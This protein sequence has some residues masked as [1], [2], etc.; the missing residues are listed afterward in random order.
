VKGN[1]F[2]WLVLFGWPLVVLAFFA[3]R[4]G[5][6]RLARTT[7]WMMLLPTMFLPSAVEYDPPGLPPLDK[8]RMAFLFIALAL[9][10]FHRRD[11]LKRAPGHNFP[12]LM[13]LIL[14]ASIVGTVRTNGDALSFGRL[15]LPGLTNH[16]VLSMGTMALLDFYLP[17]VVGQRVFRTEEDLRDL[18]GVLSLCALI[19]VPFILFEVRFSPQLHNWVYGF[20]PHSWI[21]MRRQGGFRP[22]IFMAHGLSVAMFVFSGVCASLALQRRGAP[23]ALVPYRVRTVFGWVMSVLCK[24]MAPTVY[25]VLASLLSRFAGRRVMGAVVML[26]VVSALVYPVVR[27]NGTAPTA[28]V[29][30]YLQGFSP[31]RAQSLDFRFDNEDRL[32]AHANLRP[33]FGWGGFGR[34]RVYSDT[35]RDL[36]VTDGYWIILLGV[37]GYVGWAAV[38]VLH[39]APLVRFVRRQRHM[40]DGVREMLAVFTF[41]VA[42][43][44]FDFLPNAPWDYLPMAYAGAL[45]TVSESASRPPPSSHEDGG[46]PIED[47]VPSP[48]PPGEG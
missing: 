22:L 4:R 41:M 47:P 7:A 29:I 11:I 46:I 48:R 23:A 40:P 12:R 16:D 26:V 32:L 38:F 25:V 2:A 17:F 43:M 5:Q 10:L 18:L 35:G 20:F 24:S 1:A 21:Q 19:Y 8:H 27:A 6:Y 45:W 44:V 33:L 31:E 37:L 34:N 36:S 28:E 42:M 15:T 30:E 39:L 13:L 3:M 9:Q 14:L